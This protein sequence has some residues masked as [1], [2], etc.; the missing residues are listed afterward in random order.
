MKLSVLHQRGR[1]REFRD[2]GPAV[3][4]VGRGWWHHRDRRPGDAAALAIDC[5][6]VEAEVAGLVEAAGL[7][8]GTSREVTMR[9]SRVQRDF[10]AVWPGTI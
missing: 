10:R 4:A 7:S 2:S 3:I 8:G 5:L 6:N 1:F 9:A